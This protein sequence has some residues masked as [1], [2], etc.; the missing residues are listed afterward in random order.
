MLY[1]GPEIV[2][3]VASAV[4]AVAGVALLFWQRVRALGRRAAEWAR[5]RLPGGPRPGT[6][7]VSDAPAAPRPPARPRRG[8]GTS[9]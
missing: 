8:T 3:P 1:F 4:A 7:K 9:G 5:S 2:A 6:R